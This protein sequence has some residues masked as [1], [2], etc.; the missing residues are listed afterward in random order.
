M[1]RSLSHRLKI[2]LGVEAGGFFLAAFLVFATLAQPAWAGFTISGNIGSV[3][4]GTE[5][6]LSRVDIDSNAKSEEGR[7]L[8]AT[9]GGFR[10]VFSREPGLF[11]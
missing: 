9:N 4:A 1:V 11:S 7:L 3:A 5:L 10:E 6:I 8:V 2:S